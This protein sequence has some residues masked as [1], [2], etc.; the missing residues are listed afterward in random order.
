VSCP[1]YLPKLKKWTSGGA[2]RVQLTRAKSAA[3]G[4]NQ[5][6][7]LLF[8]GAEGQEVLRAFDG[9]L[10]AAEELLEVG[11]ALDEIDVRGVDD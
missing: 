5:D 3:M 7:E 11:A 1:G 9:I 2:K 8:G 4:R 10:K 6:R